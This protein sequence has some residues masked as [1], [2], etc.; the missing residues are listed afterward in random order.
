[1]IAFNCKPLSANPSVEPLVFEWDALT[2]AVTG[3]S[4]AQV[5]EAAADGGVPLHPAPAWHTFSAEPLK[6]RADLAAIVGHLHQ[7]PGEL[8]GG[9][10]AVDEEPGFVEVLDAEGRVVATGEVDF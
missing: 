6:S 1:M 3:P 8:A 4:A 5:K 7:L 10:P 2:G 9:Y